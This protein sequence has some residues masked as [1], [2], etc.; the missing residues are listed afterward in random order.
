VCHHVPHELYLQTDAGSLS[1]LKAI[2]TTAASSHQ[3]PWMMRDLSHN[4]YCCTLIASSLGL[5]NGCSG[6][7]QVVEVSMWFICEHMGC[8]DE[9]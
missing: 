8:A 6:G 5:Q 1:T 2:L 3:L 7:A 9:G 4:A